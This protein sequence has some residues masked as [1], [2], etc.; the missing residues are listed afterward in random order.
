VTPGIVTPGTERGRTK[1]L[2]GA[3]GRNIGVAVEPLAASVPGARDAD[4]RPYFVGA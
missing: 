3:V 1:R 2:E 4:V